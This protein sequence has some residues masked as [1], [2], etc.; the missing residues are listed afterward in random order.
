MI[1]STL[2]NIWLSGYLATMAFW[3]AEG[4]RLGAN[5]NYPMP[6]FSGWLLTAAM[7][8]LF[9]PLYVFGRVDKRWQDRNG[10]RKGKRN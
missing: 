8:P 6:D 7:W 2:F 9:M 4:H 5:E 1:L 10:K 3:L